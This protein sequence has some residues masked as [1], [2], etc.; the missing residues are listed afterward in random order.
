MGDLARSRATIARPASTRPSWRG[1]GAP[2][3]EPIGLTLAGEDDVHLEIDQASEA[4][5]GTA[6]AAPDDGP[7]LDSRV[8][9]ALTEAAAPVARAE[10]R[11]RVRVRNERL[12]E[13]LA[14]LVATGAVLR[15]G[16]RWVVPDSR[17]P[18]P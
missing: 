18:P 12:G 15:M 4:I 2:A 16:D 5:D 7:T 13:A 6:G 1:Y 3:P 17:S 8:L 9:A 14:R 10:L 11:A